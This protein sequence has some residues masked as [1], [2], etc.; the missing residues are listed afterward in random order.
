VRFF[1]GFG[2]TAVFALALSA[3]AA[4]PAA[5]SELVPD[6][7]FGETSAVSGIPG[8][9]G[10]KLSVP[11]LPSGTCVPYDFQGEQ[12]GGASALATEFVGEGTCWLAGADRPFDIGDCDYTFEPGAQINPEKFS[13]SFSVDAECGPMTIEAGT[14]CKLTLQ[15]GS[16]LDAEYE[17]YISEG[18]PRVRISTVM[19]GMDY[20]GTGGWCSIEGSS[21]VYEATWDVE[22]SNIAG[23]PLGLRVM[24]DGA[25]I[26]ESGSKGSAQFIANTY[27]KAIASDGSDA[28]TL[29]FPSGPSL[30]CNSTTISAEISGPTADLELGS[31]FDGCLVGGVLPALAD[32]NSCNLGLGVGGSK[33]L[34]GGQVDVACDE[35]GDAIEFR[36]YTSAEF[37]ELACTIKLPA[38]TG[39]EGAT[40]FNWVDPEQSI[41]ADFDLEE[42]AYS[43]S[44]SACG[45]A[46][47]S[48]NLSGEATLVTAE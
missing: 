48:A 35:G 17:N 23:G 10:G 45:S 11:G 16:T 20:K 42:V 15:P 47:G 9:A 8:E 27:P 44:G 26:E 36:V 39:L 31:D 40:L 34:F 21:A 12:E 28:F 18:Q 25:L 29:A 32:M 14:I 41:G 7:T 33:P 24:G 30:K 43:W 6:Q 1:K 37:E 3:L 38:Q 13:G 46:S 5:A 2:G 4:V 22:G 19:E